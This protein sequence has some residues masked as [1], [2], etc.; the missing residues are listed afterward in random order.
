MVLREGL[1][2]VGVTG[3]DDAPTDSESESGG[4]GGSKNELTYEEQE[5]SVQ[6]H[7]DA[8]VDTNKLNLPVK[9]GQPS[10]EQDMAECQRRR[11][12]LKARTVPCSSKHHK[13]SRK[14]WSLFS[15]VQQ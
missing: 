13:C 4:S 10:G 12:R 7:Y 8:N 14:R 11:Q 3:R 6:L 9:R 15:L 1:G 2:G 5:P